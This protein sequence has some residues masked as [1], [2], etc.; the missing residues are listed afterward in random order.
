MSALA[1]NAFDLGIATIAACGNLDGASA[2][3]GRGNAHKALAIGDYDA[4]NGAVVAQRAGIVGGRIK[5]DIQAPTDVNAASN[6]TDF[7]TRQ[8]FNGTSG[9]TAFAGGATAIM[10]EF[11]STVFGINHSPGTL[12]AALLAQ[13]DGGTMP[14]LPNGAGKLKLESTALWQTGA[15][16][17]N[18]TPIDI[19]FSVSPGAKNLKVAIWWPETALPDTHN[20]VDL[21]VL[22][23]SG[24][25]VG[26]SAWAGSVWEKVVKTG[27][28]TAGNYTLRIIPY[29]MPRGSQSVY[30]TAIASAQ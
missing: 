4:A 22:S 8:S 13:T 1:D 5:P 16:T 28:L 2:P 21:T 19:I 25:S 18:T 15:V 30:Y 29:A 9:A 14:G 26:S 11:F 17:L 6:L 3:A 27:N 23:P 20:D 7:A 24:T 10:Y 12:Y